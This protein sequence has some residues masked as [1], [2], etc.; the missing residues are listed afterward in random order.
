[1]PQVLEQ[2]SEMYS[3]VELVITKTWWIIAPFFI[4]G[5]Y[6]VWRWRKRTKYYLAIDYILLAVDVPEDNE[7]DP[8]AFEQI[9]IGFHGAHRTFNLMETYFEG[10]IQE[11]LSLEIIGINGHVRFIIRTPAYFRDLIEANVYA[12]YPEAEITEVDDFSKYIP[13]HFPNEEFDLFGIEFH[14]VK[15]DAIPIRTYKDFLAD[16]EEKFYDPMAGV[17]EMMGRL[18]AGE[19]TWLQIIITPVL[20]LKWTEAGKKIIDEMIERKVTKKEGLFERTFIKGLHRAQKEVEDSLQVPESDQ[21]HEY[22]KKYEQESAMLFL[23]EGEKDVVKAIDENISK[24]G[25]ETKIRYI[26][27]ARKE[28]F[29]KKKG[30]SGIIG[31]MKQFHT[32]NLNSLRPDLRHDTS[33]EYF[34]KWREDR[35]KERFLRVYQLRDPHEGHAPFILNVE[36]LATIFHFPFTTVKTPTLKRAEAKKGGAP[37]DLPIEGE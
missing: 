33:V 3:I 22:P 31:A 14:L 12:Q 29:N 20:D 2:L 6:R 37:T 23:S 21:P 35:I 7:K 16:V 10:R 15:E 26:Y 24:I 4:W 36:E 18:S 28:M 13:P 30:F 9:L 11:P 32:Y 5:V 8:K 19:Q 1:M 27:V 17:T 25:Y 34:K